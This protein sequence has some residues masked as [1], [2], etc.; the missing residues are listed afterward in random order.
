MFDQRNM[1]QRVGAADNVL[2]EI[3]ELLGDSKIVE[4]TAKM[5]LLRNWTQRMIADMERA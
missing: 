2:E 4:A 3:R 5:Y 1:L